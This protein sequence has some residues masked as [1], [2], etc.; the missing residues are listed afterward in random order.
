M[1]LP[2][3]VVLSG[4][5]PHQV[6]SSIPVSRNSFTQSTFPLYHFLSN[7]SLLCPKSPTTVFFQHNS[8]LSVPLLLDLSC[9]YNASLLKFLCC[10]VISSQRPSPILSMRYEARKQSPTYSVLSSSASLSTQ[11]S[12]LASPRPGLH[13]TSTSSAP[14]LVLN[15]FGKD[16]AVSLLPP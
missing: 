7:L 13:P 3:Q 6:S 8:L 16:P 2:F 12:P 1:K 15:P 14:V 5:P 4:P 10:S 9:L 11:R